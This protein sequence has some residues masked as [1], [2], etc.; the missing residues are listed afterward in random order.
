LRESALG[1][2]S[3]YRLLRQ[4]TPR[5]RAKPISQRKAEPT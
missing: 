1:L 3:V 2:A 4:N 5:S